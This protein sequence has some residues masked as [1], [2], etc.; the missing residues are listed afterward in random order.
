MQNKIYFIGLNEYELRL[1]LSSYLKLQDVKI[2]FMESM[3]HAG[4]G[5]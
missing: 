4:E 1:I 2:L 3:K 5:N